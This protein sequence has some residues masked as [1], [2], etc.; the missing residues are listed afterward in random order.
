MNRFSVAALFAAMAFLSFAV[1]SQANG[2][3][4]RRGGGCCEV[5]TCDSAPC[6]PVA[7][8]PVQYEERKVKVC[9]QVKVE[10]EIEV[11]ECNRV[12]REEKFFYTVCVPVTTKAKRKVIECTPVTRE[13]DCVYYTLVPRQVE[14]KIQ[15]TTYQCVTENVVE[16]C[17]VTRWVCVTVVD[18]CGRCCTKRQCVTEWVERTRCV[19]RRIPVVTER[20][21]LVTVCDRVE[22]KGKKTVCDIVR[23]E[24]EIEVDVCSIEQQKR[25]GV[26]TVCDVVTS[27]VKRKVWVCENVW[28][29]ETVRVPVCAPTTCNTGCG[30]AYQSAGHRGIF[31]RGCC[32]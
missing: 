23:N 32:N 15:C 5:A 26:R 28:S 21:V 19:V 11:L 29:E 7:P 8:A 14:K 31:R 24:R 20:T 2:G 13:V 6:A 16:K 3:L 17:P 10:R 18:E 27:K 1:E 22:T 30:E 9:K 12:T 25:E 4:F